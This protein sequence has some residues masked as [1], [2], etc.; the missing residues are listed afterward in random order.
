MKKITL[1]I[2]FL[3]LLQTA[4]NAQYYY[5]GRNKV[6]YENF[7]WKVLKTQNFDVYYYE[8]IEEIAEKGA[9]IAEDSYLHLKTEFNHLVT[10]RIPLIFYNTSTH[11]Q[12][13]NTT[14]GFIPDG[15]GGFFEFMKGRVVIPF[16]GSLSQFEHV[17]KHEL[18]HVFMT[19]KITRIFS[20]RRRTDIHVPPLW[21]VEG[22]AEYYSTKWDAQA[23]QVMRDAVLNGYFVN[24]ENM[25][26]IYGSFLMYKEGQSFMEYA[27]EKY[28]HGVI[29]AVL[30]NLWV[31][32]SFEEVLAYTLGEPFDK[33]NR[34]WE[35]YLRKKYYPV[36]SDFEMPSFASEKI[37][38]RGYAFN[39]ALWRDS[40]GKEYLYF[41]ANL[42]GYSSVY[43]MKPSSES[44]P[45]LFIR[46]EKS[47]DYESL[48]LFEPS[49]AVTENGLL[50]FVSKSGG[51]DIINFFRLP[52]YKRVS[53][54]ADSSLVTISDLSLTKNGKLLF[55]S[56]DRR[57]FSDIFLL[58]TESLK[59]TRLTNDFYEDRFPVTG[60]SESVV[61][62]SSDRFDLKTM[63]LYT[64]NISTGEIKQL[65]WA[66]NNIKYP[67]PDTASNRL[68][69]TSDNDGVFN[70]Y[71]VPVNDFTKVKKHTNLLTGMS[72]PVISGDGKLYY[73]G[74]EKF[75]FG[76]YL[77]SN[78]DSLVTDADFS[79]FAAKGKVPESANNYERIPAELVKSKLPY[80]EDYTLDYAQSQVTTDPVFGTRGGAVLSVSDLLGDDK[81]YFVLYNTAEVQSDFLDNFNVELFRLRQGERLNYGYGIFNYRGRRYDLRESDEYYY[82]KSFGGFFVMQ[83]P[84]S[85]FAR[86][87]ASASFSN[88][89]REIVTNVIEKNALLLSGSVSYVFD[90]SLWGPTGPLDGARLRAALGYTADIR[91]DNIRYLSLILDGRYYL[92]TSF[93]TALALRASLY[94][95][96]GTDAR[97]YLAGGS[98]DLRGWPRFGLRGEKVWVSSAEFRFPLLDRIVLNFPFL[99]IAFPGLRGALFF[100]AG[101]VWDKTYKETIGSI[102]AGIR[103]NFFNI[104]VFRYDVGKKIENNFKNFQ[105]GLFWQFFFGWD[106]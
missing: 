57:G 54:F 26:A 9:K 77:I 11:F 52:S 96:D 91:Y 21:F 33:I 53:V 23:E 40:T 12:Q 89:N 78:P 86:L 36:V 47:E 37:T 4:V 1:F 50:A 10:Y 41:T 97:R 43:R 79:L 19:T 93:S 76:I 18:V 44:K 64:F 80:E 73:T 98:W 55:R 81:F 92:R 58:D 65:T 27:S 29:N 22:I 42:D 103:F 69:F 17:I 70:L 34:D 16:S 46:G 6:Q 99:G 15:V 8:E 94:Y 75:M 71:S 63:N 68:F 102:G 7:E 59:L 82:E 51:K 3:L 35:N 25:Y 74:F 20:E 61:I 32:E 39:P 14:P 62:F 48:R 88:L 105:E 104:L 101:S 60:A 24:L 13:T 85:T 5:F 90:N 100:D 67:L 30:E 45:E 95:N 87:E 38:P 84:L 49:V 106:F 72:T 66:E 31:S 28:G 83:Y 56:I 2:L